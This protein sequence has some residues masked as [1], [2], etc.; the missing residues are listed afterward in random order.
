MNISEVNK[1]QKVGY[2]YLIEDNKLGKK[3]SEGNL[4][5]AVIDYKNTYTGNRRVSK[6][7]LLI[8]CICVD[9]NV[10][11]IGYNN[12]SLSQ[13]TSG[14]AKGAMTGEPGSNRFSIHL[15]IYKLLKKGQ[16]V[17][18]YARWFDE[19]FKTKIDGVFK[20]DGQE[21]I[22]SLLNAIDVENFVKNKFEKEANLPDWNLQEQS[23]GYSTIAKE[24]YGAYKSLRKPRWGNKASE[25][26]ERIKNFYKS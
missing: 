7:A 5:F 1:T 9:G 17:E 14:Y 6:R 22:S 2:F 20:K 16:K 10:K 3:T 4:H 8:Y 12:S 23:E 18:F 19:R 24:L 15:E 26:F 21:P 25:L 13:L 11:K